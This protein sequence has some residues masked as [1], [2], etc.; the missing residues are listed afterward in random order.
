MFTDKE[1]AYLKGG[2]LARI[3]TTSTDLQPDVAP[4]G[5]D[6]DGVHFYVGGTKLA[7]TLKYKNVLVNPRVS[8]VIDD[9]APGGGWKARGIKIHGKA[10]LTTREE[11]YTGPGT[12]IRI[13]PE[14]KRSWG[15]D[16]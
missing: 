16:E 2:R 5:Y 13:R 8:L 7:K 12:Y 10:D 4:V 15:I 1:I 11:G 3:A 9:M 14:W 6:F